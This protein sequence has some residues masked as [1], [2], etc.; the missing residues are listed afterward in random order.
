MKKAIKVTRSKEKVPSRI[1]SASI[2]AIFIGKEPVWDGEKTTII[3]C[4]NWYSN[5]QGPKESKQYAIDYA[6]EKN[7]S[8]KDIQDL[9]NIDDD[10]FSNIGFVCRIVSTSA[11]DKHE[12]IVSK[13][14]SLLEEKSKPKSAVV[15]T[16]TVD[17]QIEP[18]TIQDRIF[19]QSTTYIAELDEYVDSFIKT[20]KL[21][22]LNP[23]DFMI[24]NLVKSVHAR[25]IQNYYLPTLE[26]LTGAYNKTDEQ[27]VEGYSSYKKPELKKFIELIQSIVDDCSKIIDNSK[28]I[29]KPR[30]KKAIS[31]DK[32]V[33]K[34]QYKKEDTEYKL[35]SVSPTEII[36][37]TQLWVFNTKYKKLGLYKS[38]D[39]SGFSIKGTTIEGFDETLSIQKTLR[40]PLDT[41]DQL[42]KAKKVELRKFMTT[43]NCK[44]VPLNGRLNS[45]TIILKVIK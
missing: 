17:K 43:I 14:K 32:K 4:L 33:A 37:A 20:K 25:Q 22:D 15:P 23:Y 35:V 11:L 9:S 28:L 44:E 18:K 2:E 12:W 34:V 5:Q 30:K 38:N 29:K 3:R 7:F 13:L 39:D 21:P 8:K 26:E 41:L 27:L 42:K 36:G 45:D 1:V 10:N 31:I 16:K 24:A 19:D 6:K 40:K